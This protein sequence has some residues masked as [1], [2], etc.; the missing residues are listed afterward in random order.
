MACTLASDGDGDL[1]GSGCA[2][3][4]VAEMVACICRMPYGGAVL[5]PGGTPPDPGDFR[6]LP[7]TRPD[8]LP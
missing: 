1:P 7:A 3:R 6:L 4:L 5:R 2:R 8:C